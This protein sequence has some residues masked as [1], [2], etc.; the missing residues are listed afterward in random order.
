MG[1]PAAPRKASMKNDPPWKKFLFM[2]LVVIATAGI[3]GVAGFYL[4]FVFPV[5]KIHGLTYLRTS[6]LIVYYGLINLFDVVGVNLFAR[7]L[8]FRWVRTTRPLKDGIWLG[9]YLLVFCWL[10]DILVY[11]LIR[12]TLP[13]VREYFLGKNQPEIGIAW[14]VAFFAAVLAGWLEARRREASAGGIK[15]PATVGIVGLILASIVLTVIGVG[16]FDIRP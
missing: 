11:I 8:Y 14:V 9:G 13:T 15:V 3:L 12:K 6:D 1:R 10:T 5:Q 16:F 4:W 7:A 2:S